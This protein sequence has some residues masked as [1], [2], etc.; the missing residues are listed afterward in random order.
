VADSPADGSAADVHRIPSPGNFAGFIG[1]CVDVDERR[2]AQDAE[3]RRAQQQLALAHDFEKWILEIVS[4]DIRDPLGTILFAARRL[5]DVAGA[6]SPERK[7]AEKVERGV[8]RIQHIVDDLLDLARQREG[9]EI[10]IAPKPADLRT[11]CRQIVD[12]IE[13]KARDRQI[14][15]ACEIDRAGGWGEHRIV[16]ALSNLISNAVQHGHQALRS[17]SA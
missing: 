10:P 4:H 8:H 3:Q 5:Q 12:E 17:M 15:L 9:E 11:V 7:H 14:T 2:R 13:A 1:S 16:Q 6:G